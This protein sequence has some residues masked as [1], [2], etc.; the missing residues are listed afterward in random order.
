MSDDSGDFNQ[1]YLPERY[2]KKV[3]ENQSRRLKRK[4]LLAGAIVVIAAI[5]MVLL[6]GIFPGLKTPTTAH[7]LV[8]APV[9]TIPPT[10][11]P[12][13]HAGLPASNVTPAETYTYPVGPGVPVQAS[14]GMISLDDAV[15]SLRVYYPAGE[16]VIMSVNYSSGSNRT[17]FGFI[18]APVNPPGGGDFVIFIDGTTGEPY[19]P[20]QENATITATKA[21]VQA[22][23]EFPGLNP[24]QVKV[25]FANDPVRG[26]E[27][28][29]I[30][31]TG[32]TEIARGG[33]DAT[34][35]EAITLILTIPHTGRPAGPS[36][37][38]DRAKAIADQYISDH[39]GGPLPL[40][41]T[42]ERYEDWGNATDPS[43]GEYVLTYER[44]FQDFPVDTDRIVIAV[45]SVTGNVLSYDKTWTTQDFAFS[46]TL[47]QAVGKRDA[48]FAMMQA[49]KNRYPDSV[50]SVRIISADI[51]WNNQH[52][53][54]VTQQPGSVPLAWKV[55]FDDAT[56][57][58]DPSLPQGIGWVDIQ[59][60]NVT[61]LE[62]RH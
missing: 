25:W 20:G 29:F 31:L 24:E 27:W 53:P 57:R 18:L 38:Q 21:K 59:T 4:L 51:R 8:T 2:R 9:T 28:Q 14:G 10:T 52:T 26:G 5:A 58:A 41:M 49:A 60:G 22:L 19:M 37:D 23:S 47:E 34:T 11:V 32:N 6:S 55:L 61:E 40:N 16:S 42:A 54:G 56:I 62:Y 39:N 43:A 12:A 13:G 36:I 44:I 1:P 48:T 17:L 46:Q 50:E 45:D 35:G 7:P 15:N 30:F 33:I 3:R